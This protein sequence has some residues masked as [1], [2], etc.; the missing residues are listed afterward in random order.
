M[1]YIRI[2]HFN[3]ILL[4]WFTFEKKEEILSRTRLIAGQM[5][6]TNVNVFYPEGVDLTLRRSVC[7]YGAP[8]IQETPA[9]SVFTA[10]GQQAVAR[11]GPL[12]AGIR[13]VHA[14]NLKREAIWFTC[15]HHHRLVKCSREMLLPVSCALESGTTVSLWRP[16]LLG[17]CV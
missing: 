8:D 12:R 3:L 5:C 6:E 4:F 2:F 1:I 16:E 14:F 15:R 10:G 9:A 13:H 11:R 17:V 7:S